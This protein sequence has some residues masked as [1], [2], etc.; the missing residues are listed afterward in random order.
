MTS[1]GDVGGYDFED[2]Y[3]LYLL[4]R[5]DST[6]EEFRQNVSV[7]FTGQYYRVNTTTNGTLGEKK[8]FYT[9]NSTGGIEF[10]THRYPNSHD[11]R[12]AGA[13]RVWQQT[14][15]YYAHSY[16]LDYV[17]DYSEGIVQYYG[18]YYQ[19]EYDSHY[20]LSFRNAT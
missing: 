2:I 19:M 18:S 6:R 5:P 12:R 13:V 1:K 14:S 10:N 20:E 8:F 3:G 17:T 7:N 9:F 15:Y 16:M 11:L 4:Y